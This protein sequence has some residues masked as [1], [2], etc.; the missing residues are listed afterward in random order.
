MKYTA[1]E[2][3]ENAEIS[4]ANADVV[5]GL[6]YKETIDK[7]VKALEFLLE[8]LDP[9]SKRAFEIADELGTLKEL[10]DM[11]PEDLCHDMWVRKNIKIK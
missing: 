9:N 4:Q 5:K 7:E 10:Q 2:E 1:T 6:M 8:Q 11:T 3:F